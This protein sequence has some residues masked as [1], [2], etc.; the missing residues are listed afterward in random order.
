M[1]FTDTWT[2]EIRLNIKQEQDTMELKQDTMEW[3]LHKQ[4]PKTCRD[5]KYPIITFAA[6]TLLGAI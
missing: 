6:V 5:K 1:H 3:L 4:H 2:F